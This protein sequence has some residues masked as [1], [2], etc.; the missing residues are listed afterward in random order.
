MH[1][2]AVLRL[3]LGDGNDVTRVSAFSHLLQ[4]HLPAPDTLDAIV[5]T[6][7]GI[8]GVVQISY[9]TTF[10]GPVFEVACERGVVRVDGFDTVVVMAEGREADNWTGGGLS[11]STIAVIDS[12]VGEMQGENPEKR[13]S[14]RQALKDLQ[15]VSLVSRLTFMSAYTDNCEDQGNVKEC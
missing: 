12:W 5:K 2:I 1:G 14:V 10:E 15:I 6:S 13:L 8:T 7:T 11:E 3:L 4:S 9:G